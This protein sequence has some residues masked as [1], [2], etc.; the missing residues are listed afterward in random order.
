MKYPVLDAKVLIRAR[1]GDAAAFEEIL[2]AY[3][4]YV[5][6]LALSLTENKQDAEDVT[7]EAFLKLWRS[8]PE[9]RGEVQSLGAYVMRIARNAAL[10]LLRRRK[11]TPLPLVYSDENGEEQE[12]DPPD[13]APL[14]AEEY[15]RKCDAAQLR[16]AIAKLPEDMQRILLLRHMANADYAEIAE[17]LAIPEGTVKSRLHR[18]RKRLYSILLELL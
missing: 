2:T 6:S 11:N 14:P 4:G 5:Y 18:A 3:G 7:Q 17:L 8:L 9:F 1:S 12:I 10:D 16:A 13:P 15:I